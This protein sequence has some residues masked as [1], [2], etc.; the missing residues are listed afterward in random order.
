MKS[1]NNAGDKLNLLQ[2]N[3]WL[4]NTLTEAGRLLVEHHRA[5]CDAETATLSRLSA[6]QSLPQ[7]LKC[8]VSQ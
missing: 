3:I 6:L 1:L 5:R 2:E 7:L 4:K 8:P